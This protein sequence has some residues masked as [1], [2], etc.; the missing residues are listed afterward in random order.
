MAAILLRHAVAWTAPLRW[1]SS[2]HCPCCHG[3]SQLQTAARGWATASGES[4]PGSGEA[5]GQTA[6]LATRALP[7]VL[8]RSSRA[9]GAAGSWLL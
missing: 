4:A 6:T 5:P 2:L 9:G 8:N 1:L 7:A 3:P